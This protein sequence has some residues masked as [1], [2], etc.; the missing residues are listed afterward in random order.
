MEIRDRVRFRDQ[1]N[2]ILV[3]LCCQAKCVFE[4]EL[5]LYYPVDAENE[6]Y[7]EFPL[8]GGDLTELR[9]YN[10]RTN[11]HLPKTFIIVL[12]APTIVRIYA[13]GKVIPR[14][15]WRNRTRTT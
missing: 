12:L 11:I 13:L 4:Y 10:V 6:L 8:G 14:G 5:G 15:S 3:R 1:R 7:H 2:P 9:Y